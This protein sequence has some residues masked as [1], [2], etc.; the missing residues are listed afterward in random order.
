MAGIRK[1]PHSDTYGEG[2][3]Y[4]EILPER[5][6]NARDDPKIDDADAGRSA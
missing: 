2:K 5:A 4:F 6:R 1:T 3:A